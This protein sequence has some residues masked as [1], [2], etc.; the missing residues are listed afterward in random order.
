M[1]DIRSLVTLKAVYLSSFI[2]W[3][4]MNFRTF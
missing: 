1:D 4:Q 3:K 2:S